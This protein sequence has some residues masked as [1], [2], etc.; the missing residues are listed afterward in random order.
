[1]YG[2]SSPRQHGL[3]SFNLC[4]D[5]ENCLF[6]KLNRHGLTWLSSLKN[7]R[8]GLFLLGTLHVRLSILGLI[9]SKGWLTVAY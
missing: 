1:M 7:C 8:V 6:S 2:Q 3:I 9:P 5:R 4:E